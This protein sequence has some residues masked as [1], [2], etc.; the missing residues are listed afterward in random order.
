VNL[1]AARISVIPAGILGDCR[2]CGGRGYHRRLCHRVRCQDC[3]GLGFF[4]I[5][6]GGVQS[7]PARNQRPEGGEEK[8]KVASALTLLGL[9][10]LLACAKEGT[11]VVFLDAGGD[12]GGAVRGPSGVDTAPVP[13]AVPPQFDVLLSQSDASPD[14]V[15]AGG[16]SPD[17]GSEA[18]GEVRQGTLGDAGWF[19]CADVD[20][21][22]R[23][24]L[25]PIGPATLPLRLEGED[26]F[27]KVALLPGEVPCLRK[28]ALSDGTGFNRWVLV[29]SC[30]ECPQ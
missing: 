25:C 6:G 9:L 30:A 18:G 14:T 3:G 1:R 20:G 15:E 29:A 4:R 17:A 26:W 22:Y 7:I 5:P 21:G 10:L 12:V 13:D 23:G 16:L 2:S 28:V 8:T 27:C 19:A 24:D 11:E